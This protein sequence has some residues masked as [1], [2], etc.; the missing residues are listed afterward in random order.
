MTNTRHSEASPELDPRVLEAL[1]S[2][3][4]HYEVISH[5]QFEQPIRSPQDFAQAA[6]CD[7]RSVAKSILLRSVNPDALVMVV[8]PSKASIG[9]EAVQQVLGAHSLSLVGRKEVEA[10]T[11]Q[12]LHGVSP[13]GHDSFSIL[14]DESLFS[15]QSIFV[16]SGRAGQEIK[17]APE[18][19]R[20]V[21]RARVGSFA[22]S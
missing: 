17:I 6:N 12:Q 14:M 7:I 21:T 13:L 9:V 10:L 4:A 2:S 19:L 16:G 3:G 20:E 8:L 15:H 22:S 1:Q 5:A 18:E 11:T